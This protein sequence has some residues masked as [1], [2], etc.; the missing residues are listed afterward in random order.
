M[1]AR[2]ATRQAHTPAR[3]YGMRPTLAVPAKRLIGLH[4]L[5]VGCASKASHRPARSADWLCQQSVSWAFTLCML[6]V[7]A[8]RLIGLHALH[9][10]CANKASHGPAHCSSKRWRAEAAWQ[11]TA[12]LLPAFPCTRTHAHIHTTVALNGERYPPFVHRS[13]FTRRPMTGRRRSRRQPATPTLLNLS[14]TL[15]WRSACFQISD[16]S[17]SSGSSGSE[18]VE[19]VDP[20]ARAPSKG[21]KGITDVA[22]QVTVRSGGRGRGQEV[23]KC[24]GIFKKLAKKKAKVC[25]FERKGRQTKLLTHCLAR[26]GW[27]ISYG[28]CCIG[29]LNCVHRGELCPSECDCSTRGAPP[30]TV[31]RSEQP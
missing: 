21:I 30:F 3:V 20:P 13:S 22:M 12:P 11:A 23:W 15:R 16:A 5:Q 8:K 14:H 27:P 9:V 17:G 31:H 24:N 28:L 6:A 25:G 4:A 26:D 10:G 19:A 18:G 7:P 2:R 1:D 29:S